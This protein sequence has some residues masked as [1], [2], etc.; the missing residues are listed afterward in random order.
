MADLQRTSSISD[1][2]DPEDWAKTEN[3]EIMAR[4]IVDGF[5]SGRHRSR[6]KG[7][8]SEFAEHRMYSPGDEIRLL[9]WRVFGKSDRYCIKQFEEEISLQ[10]IV[11]MDAS[12]SMGFGKET[13]SKFEYSRR[14]AL[15]LSRL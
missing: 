10:A 11:V 3:L 2:V 13:I 1:F 8:S 5:L 14:A 4:H 7:G 12:G 6:R 9:D 15:C